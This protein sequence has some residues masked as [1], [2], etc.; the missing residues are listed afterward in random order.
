MAEIADSHAFSPFLP[1]LILLIF[2]SMTNRNVVGY[3]WTRLHRQS[4]L[5]FLAHS[6]R[7]HTSMLAQLQVTS[8]E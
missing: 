3:H 6:F 5:P 1:P 2:H 7:L 8:V 4:L